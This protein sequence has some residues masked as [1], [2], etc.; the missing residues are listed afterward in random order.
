MAPAN[1]LFL[2]YAP[3]FF[4]L[5]AA[6]VSLT[7]VLSIGL[8]GSAGNHPISAQIVL[9]S[10]VTPFA[11]TDSCT[12]T[13]YLNGQVSNSSIA[14]GMASNYTAVFT[15]TSSGSTAPPIT[16]MLFVNGKKVNNFTT[17]QGPTGNFTLGRIK[18]RSAGNYSVVANS[19]GATT[20]CR[21][22]LKQTVSKALPTLSL[23]SSS[24]NFTYNGSALS[25]TGS[26]VS[27]AAGLAGNLYING[28]LSINPYSN[29][30]AGTY[31][32]VFNTSGNQ[33]YSAASL[34]LIR[35]I[36]TAMP[37]LS[38]GAKLAN[39]TYNTTQ[40]NFTVHVSSVNNQVSGNFYKNGVKLALS[41][42]NTLYYL[43]GTAGV[44]SLI[45]NNSASQNYSSAT[46]SLARQISKAH[47]A[48]LLNAS[49]GN[50]TYNGTAEK[51]SVYSSTPSITTKL[52]INGKN[53]TSPYLNGTAGSLY[54]VYN[55]SGN[56]NYT[57]A[58]VTSA[59]AITRAVPA[60]A[61][62]SKPEINYTEN[63]TN[64]K[65]IA[66]ISSIGNQLIGELVVNDLIGTL[67]L[68]KSFNSGYIMNLGQTDGIWQANFSTS[69]DTNYTQYSTSLT[70]QLSESTTNLFDLFL[71]GIEGINVSAVYG[72]QSNFTA[73]APSSYEWVSLYINGTKIAG[74]SK[75]KIIYLS[76]LSTGVYNVSAITN[77]S[78]LR[79]ITNYYTIL[80]RSPDIQISPSIYG[81]FSYN[82]SIDSVAFN[83]NSVDNQI[84]LNVSLNGTL[85]NITRSRFVYNISLPG[86]YNFTVHTPGDENYTSLVLTKIISILTSKA[87]VSIITTNTEQGMHLIVPVHLLNDTN[88][89]I[90]VDMYKLN[91]SFLQFRLNMF[92]PSNNITI[93]LPTSLLPITKIVFASSSSLIA[94]ELRISAPVK[95][96][97]G[98][99]ALPNAIKFFNITAFFSERPVLK[100]ISYGF[101]LSKRMFVDIP[102]ATVNNVALYRCD[103]N[104]STWQ[105][106]PTRL[107]SGNY[108]YANYLGTSNGTSLYAIGLINQ[109]ASHILVQTR[110]N[111]SGLPYGYSYRIKYINSTLSAVTPSAIIF[112]S[113]AG[114]YP[115]SADVLSNSSF[116]W[117]NLCTTTYSPVDA[118]VYPIIVPAGSSLTIMY[119]APSTSCVNVVAPLYGSGFTIPLTVGALVA[120]FLSL[121]FLIIL[122]N[123]H[124]KHNAHA[125]LRPRLT[126]ASFL[127]FALGLFWLALAFIGMDLSRTLVN[128][129]AQAIVAQVL[130]VFA[131]VLSLFYIFA[132]SQIRNRKKYGGILGIIAIAL[133][134]PVN[135]LLL[136]VGAG[137]IP[138]VLLFSSIPSLEFAVVG[139]AGL[140]IDFLIGVLIAFEWKSFRR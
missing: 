136:Y 36:Y 96:T 18:L 8:V 43:N 104:S 110:V 80:K 58:S 139:L 81:N 106:L 73:T 61:L 47:P 98:S 91:N 75:N 72:T 131:I 133:A 103:R 34:L 112:N 27:P 114:N 82:G 67:S 117:P 70:R 94:P 35:K 124:T 32:A 113:S 122:K 115:L 7:F 121:L 130:S 76:N 101:S 92:L 64:L 62:S 28:K 5:I 46:Y 14:Y 37:V 128:V 77:E 86:I 127:L 4:S 17:S 109:S 40:E 66:N 85:I 105:I 49:L 41:V 79:I 25:F 119:S 69:G 20:N 126:W 45:L 63:G 107:L 137:Y 52:Y 53:A 87:P 125:V 50:F 29:R 54:A 118:A 135:I 15:A 16:Y 26:V 68:N 102:W 55:S 6:L 116:A 108:T 111:T 56:V 65:F 60:L 21:Q 74:P 12:V 48:I 1:K 3:I 31:A 138:S 99:T 44:Y 22:A 11:K 83:I 51:F 38:L 33:N 59:R 57:P 24:S 71:D 39:Y 13:L 30:S 95:T 140:V 23:S 84:P 10:V 134:L 78:G 123:R 89:G 97:C 93:P 129:P 42:N 9:N 100:N 120:L 19:S 90:L 2:K 132:A 88:S